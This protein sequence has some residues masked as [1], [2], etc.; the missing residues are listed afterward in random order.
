M[1]KWYGIRIE[2][3]FLAWSQQ[4]AADG[5]L[6]FCKP[7]HGAHTGGKTLA[8]SDESVAVFMVLTFIFN[9]MTFKKKLSFQGSRKVCKYA[10]LPYF[11]NTGQSDVQHF[12]TRQSCVK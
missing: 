3:T 8:S 2:H 7:L 12:A 10:T 11:Q 9:I 4:Y 1:W 5:T 6:G